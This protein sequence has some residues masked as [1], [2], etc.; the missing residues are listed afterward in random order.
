MSNRHPH[1]LLLA[2]TL[3]VVTACGGGGQP[4][5][6]QAPAAGGEAAAPAVDEAT[7]ATVTGRV[8]FEGTA[9]EPQVIRM[10]A[11]PECQ[12]QYTEGPF[13]EE[14]VVNDN[15]TLQ[16][17]FVYVKEGLGDRTFPA[18]QE[19]VVLDQQGCR[20]TPHVL[21]AQTNQPVLIRNSDPTGHNIH[22]MPKNSRGF[23]LGQP[24]QGLEATRSFAKSEVMIPVECDIH[25]W[26]KAYIGVLDHP[27]FSVTGDDGS[28]TLAS[29]PPGDYVIEAWHEKYGTQTMTV[30]VGEKESKEI[31]FTFKSG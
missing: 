2:A 17:V 31:E 4:T 20:Y 8:L 1:W 25:G 16:N 15:G 18:P 29:L 22:P 23:N 9:P 11:E 26:M 30:S 5:G 27:Y 10:D 28:F 6:G 12:K 19:P 21:G 14:V 13:T 3:L 7:A 24:R